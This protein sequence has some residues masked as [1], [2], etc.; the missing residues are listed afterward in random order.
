MTST[1]SNND[2]T[3]SIHDPS[4]SMGWE[5]FGRGAVRKGNY[6][7]VHIEPNMGGRADGKW[8]LYD[9][10][11]DQGEIEDLADSKPEIVQDLLK[12]WEKY[13]AETGVVWGTPIRYVGDE[14]DG[15][16]EDGIIGGDAITQTTA[17]MKVRQ[18][19]AP[20]PIVK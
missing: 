4:S 19:Q 9:L 13:R 17:W 5:L 2:S 1:S 8:Q 16:E 11:T 7:L 12:V 6:K 3:H 18:N 20:T 15:N 14:W 10:S